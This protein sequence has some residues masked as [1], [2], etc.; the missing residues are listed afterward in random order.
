MPT[1]LLLLPLLGGYL[2]LR[3]C[4]YCRF[5]SQHIDGYRLVTVLGGIL[6]IDALR[7]AWFQFAPVPFA[8]TAM[9]AFLLGLMLPPVVNRFVDPLKAKTLAVERSGDEVAMLLHDAML[10]ERP[11]AVALSD[12]KFYVGLVLRS[13]NLDPREQHTAMLP[14]ASGYRDPETLRFRFT[15]DYV[16]AY[17]AQEEPI[18]PQDFVVVFPLQSISTVRFFDAGIYD[19]AFG[20][21]TESESEDHGGE[22]KQ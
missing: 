22:Q 14:L 1:N 17:D 20:Q 15:T 18:D 4:H 16:P 9:G 21:A 2:F 11:V 5:R 7:E 12:R 13:P 8:G 10:Q 19:R 6:P 3:T